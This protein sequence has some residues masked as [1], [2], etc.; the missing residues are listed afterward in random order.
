MIGDFWHKRNLGPDE[1]D[2]KNLAN[3]TTEFASYILKIEKYLSKKVTR[4][5]GETAISALGNTTL[6]SI[7]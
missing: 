7:G 3:Q 4:S 1:R 2:I 5:S 6:D